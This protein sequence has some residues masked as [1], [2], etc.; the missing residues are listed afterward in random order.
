MKALVL[1]LVALAVTMAFTG[2]LL[3]GLPPDALLLLLVAGAVQVMV[4]LVITEPPV[5]GSG[6][7]SDH[8]SRPTELR[9]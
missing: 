7:D 8:S 4:S 2:G 6:H 1:G 3:A 9:N 5:H